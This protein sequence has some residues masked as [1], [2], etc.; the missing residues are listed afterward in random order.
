MFKGVFCLRH[1]NCLFH[2]VKLYVLTGKPSKLYDRTNIDWAPTLKMGHSFLKSSSEV[3]A[4]IARCGRAAERERKRKLS[5][6][7]RC[8]VKK[9]KSTAFIAVGTQIDANDTMAN[10]FQGPFF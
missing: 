10:K 8:T 3:S 6:D 4:A 9:A 5:E 1:V 7:V 2:I